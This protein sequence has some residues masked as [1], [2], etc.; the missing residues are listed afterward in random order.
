MRIDRNT[1]L[2]TEENMV[3]GFIKA[4]STH[5]TVWQSQRVVLYTQA[6]EKK[7]LGFKEYGWFRCKMRD[8]TKV[9]FLMINTQY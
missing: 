6:L 8:I 2:V 1:M 5:D 3:K 4:E 7:L 9:L